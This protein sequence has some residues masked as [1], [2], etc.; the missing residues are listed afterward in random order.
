VLRIAAFPEE[1]VLKPYFQPNAL[2]CFKIFL[3]K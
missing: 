2:K 3:K 1:H